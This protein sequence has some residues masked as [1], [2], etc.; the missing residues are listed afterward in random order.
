MI[1]F[2]LLAFVLTLFSLTQWAC[3]TANSG[4]PATAASTPAATP[5]PLAD[6]KPEDLVV[7]E[8]RRAMWGG[9]ATVQYVG[10][11]LDGTV[12]DEGK[13]DFTIG[14]KTIIR[15]F[16]IAVGGSEGLEAMKVGGKRR[17]MLTPD[18]AYGAAGDG[19][20]IPPNATL[21]FEIELLKVQGGLGF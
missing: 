9:K 1:R 2:M 19:R 5:T 11:L 20:K 15:G 17:V 4:A 3:Q 7:G 12:V 8:G 6:L 10:K 16:N 18:W 14:D 13:L 21:T